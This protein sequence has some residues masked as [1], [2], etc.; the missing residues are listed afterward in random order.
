MLEVV[1]AKYWANLGEMTLDYSVEFHGVKPERPVITMHGADGILSLE[2]RSGLRR[3]KISPAI[4][5]KN[6][7]Q[8]LRWVAHIDLFSVG[9]AYWLVAEVSLMYDIYVYAYYF[10]VYQYYQYLF[11][12][13]MP[14]YIRQPIITIFNFQESAYIHISH[15]FM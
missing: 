1:V 11:E 2:L 3:E 15:A 5:L 7:V 13:K 10:E 8:V 14:L 9:I 6:A 12:Y 4:T